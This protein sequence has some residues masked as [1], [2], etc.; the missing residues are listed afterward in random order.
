MRGSFHR[1]SARSTYSNA[2]LRSTGNS[3]VPP[4]EKGALLSR[5]PSQSSV[6]VRRDRKFESSIGIDSRSCILNGRAP[7]ANRF[8][9]VNLCVCSTIQTHT[10]GAQ[11]SLDASPRTW[12]TPLDMRTPEPDD[13][14]HNPSATRD[15][16]W[17]SRGSIMTKRGVLNL[18]CL[19]VLTVGLL[20]LL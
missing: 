8:V 3:A 10:F 2:S 16:K 17:D 4:N 1:Q 14:L 12:G 9:A 19:A 11:F 6:K 18:G 5:I 7:S 15:R 20:M 13:D